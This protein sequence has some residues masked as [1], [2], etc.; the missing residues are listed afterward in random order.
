M[1]I[2][3]VHRNPMQPKAWKGKKKNMPKL[4]SLLEVSL[5]KVRME[6]SIDHLN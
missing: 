5:V 2:Y 3:T 1:E 4:H 6:N